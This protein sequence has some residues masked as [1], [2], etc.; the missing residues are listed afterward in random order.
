[1]LHRMSLKKQFYIVSTIL[2]LGSVLLGVFI[3]YPT[4]KKMFTVSDSIKQMQQ[5]LEDEYNNTQAMKRTIRELDSVNKEVETYKQF[6]MPNDDQLAIIEELEALATQH[7][8]QQT[9]GAT[10]SNTAD[11]LVGLPYYT[12]SF[13]LT[14]PFTDIFAYIKT[15]E[16]QPY[17][18]LI[19]QIDLQRSGESGSASLR[20]E[21]RMYARAMPPS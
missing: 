18:V 9:L 4:L 21:A 8:L 10:Y 15:L 2:F 5:E 13:V 14:G 6:A 7:H 12:F 17:Y 19:P 16:A 1:M 11:A 3:I 20:F